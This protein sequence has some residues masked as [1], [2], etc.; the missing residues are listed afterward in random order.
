MMIPSIILNTGYLIPLLGLGTYKLGYETI[1]KA[2][3]VGYRHFDTATGYKNHRIIGKAIAPYKRAE[4]FITTKINPSDIENRTVAQVVDT[5]LAEL[6]TSYID[7]LLVHSPNLP[8]IKTVLEMKDVQASGK[9][10]TIGVSNCT[11]HHLQDLLDAGI[12]ISVNQVEFHPYLNQQ[13]LLNFCKKNNIILMGYR[14]L[15]KGMITQDAVL[16]SIAQNHFKSQ[17]Q[18]ALRWAIQK[19]IPI[20]PRADKEEHLQANMALFDFELTETEMYFIDGLN[21]NERTCTG[22]WAQFNY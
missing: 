10:R 16:A 17:A 8:L 18:I 2:L 22:P 5:I 21:R 1:S 9:V 6:N 3:N 11:I 15:V 13:E 7:L 19:G 20:I 14:P 4:I 12:K